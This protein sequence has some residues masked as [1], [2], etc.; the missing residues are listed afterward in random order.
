MP[1][2][3]TSEP[4]AGR[5]ALVTGTS[6]GIGQAIAV[7]L[8]QR[9]A[10]V[11]LGDRGDASETIALIADTGHKAVPVTLDVSDPSSIEAARERVAEEVGARRH[12]GQQRWDLRGCDLG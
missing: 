1:T 3:N 5:V 4:H 8:A 9:G 12:P 2:N 7:G 11:V 6:R 10:R